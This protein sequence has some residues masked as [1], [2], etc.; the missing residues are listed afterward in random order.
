M[1]SNGRFCRTL[2]FRKEGVTRTE[3]LTGANRDNREQAPLFPSV[4]FLIRSLFFLIRRGQVFIAGK[5][6]AQNFFKPTMEIERK[7]A[8][9][10]RG[11]PHPNFTTKDTK[12][13]KK[14]R[15]RS[16][17]CKTS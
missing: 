7:D 3:R 5:A 17:L 6:H 10:Q 16:F 4:W 2:H 15:F 13:T 14:R 12:S 11:K 8:E 9:A 1:G